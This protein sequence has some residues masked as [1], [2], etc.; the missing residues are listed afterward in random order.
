MKNAT[1]MKMQVELENNYN[2]LE[3]INAEAKY[4]DKRIEVAKNDNDE[5]AEAYWK[6]M[7]SDNIKK[8][9]DIRYDIDLLETLIECANFKVKAS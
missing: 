5:Q 1:I 6:N 9:E 7:M 8:T 3:I 2:N 4:I